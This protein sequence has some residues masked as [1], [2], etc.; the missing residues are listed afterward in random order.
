[1]TRRQ[2]KRPPCRLFYSGLL[3][4]LTLVPTPAGEV[5][6]PGKL[7]GKERETESEE[8]V[9]LQNEKLKIGFLKSHGAALAYLSAT[10]NDNNV[11][12]HYDRGRL[13]QQS[14]YGD[15][16][17]SKWV[18][19]PWR[20]NPVQGGDYRGTPAK[21]L[22]FK[23]TETTA[24]A[25]TIP[26]HW[27]SGELVES[28]LMEQWAELE[29]DVI[30]MKYKFSYN[31]EKSHA[32]RHQETPAVFV[33]PRLHT[34]VTYEGR[35]PWKG[36]TLTRRSPGW[37]NER[38]RLSEPW[39]AW[40]DEQGRGVGICVPGTLEATT[41]RFQGGRGS[42]CSYI[43]PLRTFA[44]TPGL[45]FTYHAYLTLGSAEEIRRTFQALIEEDRVIN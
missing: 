20:F 43:A 3:V 19:K 6:P 25:R 44:L 5:V 15:P 34:L 12:N 31:G 33:T 23:S 39:A 36:G 24:Y 29:G 28:C 13:V 16:D 35:E 42:S 26:R 17:Q 27:A 38:V 8:W 4:L 22:E 11:L 41:Y 10:E 2:K 30:K 7:S 40:V 18:D 37:P 32:A 45:T 21:V 14:Y 1:M 9:Y